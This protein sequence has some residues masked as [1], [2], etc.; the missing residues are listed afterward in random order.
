MIKLTLTIHIATFLI[1]VSNLG[2]QYSSPESVTYDSIGKRYLVSNTSGQ[3]ISQRSQTGAVTDFVTVGG[4]IHGVTVYNNKVYVCNGTRIKGYDLTNAAEIFNV[5]LTGSTFLNDLAADENG[6]LYVTDFTNRRI[7][8]VNTQNGDWWIYVTNTTNT[9]NGIYVD[10]VRNRLLVCCWG[11]N[12]PVKSVNLAD[13][14]VSNLITTPYGNCDG[15]SL[16]KYDNVYI[17]TWSAQSVVRYDINFSGPPFPVVSGLSNPADIY[18][19][20]ATDTLAV[21]NA[22]NNTVTFH[23]L[24]YPSGVNL[25]QT[26]IPNSSVLYQ[27]Y[28][29]PFNPETVIRFDLS[30]SKFISLKIFDI[31]GNEI[32]SLLNEKKSTGNYEIKFDGSSLSGGV[33]FYRLSADGVSVD[34]KSMMLIK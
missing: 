7:Y 14:S 17:S 19:N 24:D 4:S 27:N 25:N 9:P 21:P 3:K 2:A 23:L 16:D 32:A 12:A 15:I 20:K 13:S 33:Y 28:P 18:V 11:S 26:G 6:M 1:S 8:K 34:T 30:E 10:A 22:S 31:L 29:N 5:T